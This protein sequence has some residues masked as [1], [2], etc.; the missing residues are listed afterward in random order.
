MSSSETNE[1]W[2]AGELHQLA[3]AYPLGSERRDRGKGL[4][5]PAD[6]LGVKRWMLS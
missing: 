5:S 3:G 6:R 2:E 4:R 1:N